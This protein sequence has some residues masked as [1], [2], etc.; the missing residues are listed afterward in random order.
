MLVLSDP[1]LF[2][3]GRL[4]ARADQSRLT[5]ASFFKTISTL[6]P[7]FAMSTTEA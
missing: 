7:P 1:P 5:D 2:H 3:R 4:F 6:K